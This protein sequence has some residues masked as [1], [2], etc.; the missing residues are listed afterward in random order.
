[1]AITVRTPI[2]MKSSQRVTCLLSI[3][4][5][6]LP[7]PASLAEEK[8]EKS[9]AAPADSSERET[10][11]EKAKKDAEE[12]KF[13][14]EVKITGNDKMQY[15]RQAFTVESG[16]V[17]KLSFRNIGK[18]PKAVMGHNVVILKKGVD[19][20]TFAIAAL[21]AGL[22]AEY[23]PAAR[24]A[25]ILA[26]TKML[27]PGEEQSIIF[28]APEKGTYDYICTFPGHFAIMCGVMTVK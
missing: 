24:K 2:A 21:P 5:F 19:K 20:V 18:L 4:F 7:R 23:L 13:D 10:E 28:A 9:A 25:D 6:T 22:A 15:D 12:E 14:V 17:V 8:A 11:K 3:L 16:Q 1:M 26:H 27:G